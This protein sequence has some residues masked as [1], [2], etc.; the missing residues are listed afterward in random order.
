MADIATIGI[1][2]ERVIRDGRSLTSQLQMALDS[3]I[4]I[5]Q[6]KGVIAEHNRITVDDAFALLRGFAR[7]HNWLLSEAAGQVVDGTLKPEALA[8]RTVAEKTASD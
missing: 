7:D 2:Q 6:A 4:V 5:E 1:L 3:R 8:A